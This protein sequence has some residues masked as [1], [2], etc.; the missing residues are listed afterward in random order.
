[1]DI[2]ILS[3]EREEKK[4]KE[5]RL[6][7]RSSTMVSDGKV[8]SC[9]Y[10]S[11]YMYVSLT[12]TLVFFFPRIRI[13]FVCVCVTHIYIVTINLSAFISYVV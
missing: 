1:M 13:F 6:A 3:I 9:I 2:V 11:V 12:L 7:R 10:T 4:E 5:N 8:V